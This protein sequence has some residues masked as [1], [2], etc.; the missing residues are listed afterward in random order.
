MSI[1]VPPESQV[2]KS[3]IV[4]IRS[5]SGNNSTPDGTYWDF[6][7]CKLPSAQEQGLINELTRQA[8]AAMGPGGFFQA[9][10][11]SL[12]WMR[13]NG[14]QAEWQVATTH[15]AALVGMKA[16]PSPD[17]VHEYRMTPNGVALELYLRTRETHPEISYEKIRATI[18]EVNALE[19]FC[20]IMDVIT[21]DKKST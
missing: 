12:L 20:Q 4:R 21:D 16:N 9:S 3:G 17:A 13:E 7:V 8:K 1:I 11:E 5:A 2:S 19:I 10:R 14:M 15:I 6:I 18:T